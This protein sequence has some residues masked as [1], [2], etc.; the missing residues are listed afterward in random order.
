MYKKQKNKKLHP[1]PLPLLILSNMIEF[2]N[3]SSLEW[4]RVYAADFWSVRLGY[5]QTE[6]TMSEKLG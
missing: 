4:S 2:N 5:I 6:E 3:L 1:F